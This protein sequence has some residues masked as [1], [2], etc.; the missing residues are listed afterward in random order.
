MR[1][2]VRI[3]PAAFIVKHKLQSELFPLMNMKAVPFH[4]NPKPRLSLNLSSDP[5]LGVR[6]LDTQLL[7]PCDN[8]DSL[9]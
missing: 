6:D 9:S 7:S 3:E 5:S 1:H 8:L 4:A 2:R